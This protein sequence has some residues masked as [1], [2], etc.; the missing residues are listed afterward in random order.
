MDPEDREKA[1][2]L[3]SVR[4]PVQGRFG[5][6][7]KDS[8]LFLQDASVGEGARMTFRQVSEGEAWMDDSE[9]GW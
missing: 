8:P 3:L 1:E 2:R 7:G 5:G 9:R 4:D 6:E